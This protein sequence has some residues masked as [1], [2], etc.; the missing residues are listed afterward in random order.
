MI[1]IFLG[2]ALEAWMAYSRQGRTNVEC[3]GM[4]IS[5]VRVTNDRLIKNRAAR[6]LLKA[7]VQCVDGLKELSIVMS[8][9]LVESKV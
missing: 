7:R 4:K 3:R 1:D 5:G 8:R 2:K 6:T 9:F